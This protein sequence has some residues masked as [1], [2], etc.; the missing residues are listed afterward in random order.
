MSQT[1]VVADAAS[2]SLSP[3]PITPAWIL[4]GAPV[5]RARPLA[6]SRDKTANIVVW[7]C[8]PGLFNWHYAEDETVFVIS[9]EVFITTANGAERRLGQ[10]DMAF[11]PAGSSCAWRVT[12]CVRK[13]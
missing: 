7:E 13:V 1:I 8:T 5:A 2:A 4:Q 12:Q 11:F 3:S 6:K 10:G 9:G